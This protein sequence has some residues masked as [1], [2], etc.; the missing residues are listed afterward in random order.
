MSFN[1]GQFNPYIRNI[2]VDI[3]E[4]FSSADI[5]ATLR[6][7]A[8]K[9]IANKEIQLSEELIISELQKVVSLTKTNPEKINKIREWG[10]ER[11]IPASK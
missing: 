11:A 8:Y 5:E 1:V 4:G 2:L 7:L 3:T 10:K 9:I 6:N